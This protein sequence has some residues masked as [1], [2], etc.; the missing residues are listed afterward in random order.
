VHLQ[1]PFQ[2]NGSLSFIKNNVLKTN[3]WGQNSIR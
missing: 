3:L 2:V 1:C